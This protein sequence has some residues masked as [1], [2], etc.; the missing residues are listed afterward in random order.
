MDEAPPEKKQRTSSSSSSSGAVAPAAAAEAVDENGLPILRN[1]S[2][3][4]FDFKDAR[5]TID[6][7]HIYYC[8]T[9]A[10]ALPSALHALYAFDDDLARHCSYL[11]D[12]VAATMEQIFATDVRCVSE[13]INAAIHPHC[14]QV[15]DSS[16]AVFFMDTVVAQTVHIDNNAP[17]AK[18]MGIDWPT[19]E[20]QQ[21]QH[22]TIFCA[23]SSFT[24]IVLPLH[25]EVEKHWSLLVFYREAAH[26]AHWHAVHYD[27]LNGLNHTE[28][29]HF[30]SKFCTLLGVVEPEF[31][32]LDNNNYEPVE[33]AQ[34][35]KQPDGWSCGYR[36]IMM[37]LSVAYCAGARE[38]FHATLATQTYTTN[39]ACAM[40]TA[41]V[42]ERCAKFETLLA[43]RQRCR[44]L[45]E[46]K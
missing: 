41:R 19:T 4:L 20:Q 25:S 24:A 28:A 32:L 16:R 34:T 30:L 26:T 22:K 31:C 44:N 14:S 10:T 40:Y 7:A 9:S 11:Y 38:L 17:F 13:F 27:T 37:A 45:F 35:P 29:T 33:C 3:L 43:M 21:Q 1:D 12:Q 8:A 18:R 39:R 42:I 6:M 23:D 15:A 2:V 46:F 5:N 36:V